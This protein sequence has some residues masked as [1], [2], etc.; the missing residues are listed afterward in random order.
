VISGFLF[1][2]SFLV[3]LAPVAALADVI[4][5][6]RGGLII[7]R[8]THEDSKQVTYEVPGGEVS[9][10]MSEVD[11]VVKSA[12]QAV[13]QAPEEN[14]TSPVNARQVPLPSAPS[15]EPSP[16]TDSP[17][18]KDGAIDEAYLVHLGN[19]LA[20]NPSAEN[21]HLLKQ[22]YQQAALF[23]ARQGDPDG[24]IQKY[25]EALKLLPGDLALTLA[26]GYLQVTQNHY[27]EAIDLLLPAADLHPKSA[28]IPMLLGSAY[29]GMENLDEA[30][31]QWN[32]ALDISDNPRI[33]AAIAKTEREREISGSYSELRSEHFL[34]RYEGRQGEKLS[35]EVLN[36]LEKS[37][38]DLVFDLDYNP[39]ETIVVLLYPD[40]AFRDI[41]RSPS[42]V[43]A[44]ND[45]KI[46]VPVS[47]LSQLNADL[48]RVL[49]HEL[50]HS[51]VRQITGGR[52]PTWFNE[53]L[54]QIEEGATTASM[55]SRLARAVA[56]G[57]L[58][59]LAS[60][61]GPAASAGAGQSTSSS[62]LQGP[63]LT[64]PKDQAV[65]AYAKS[66][67][68]VEYL[69]SNFDMSEIRRLLKA[70]PSQPDFGALLQDELHYNYSGF[71]QEVA[72]YI[73]RK[74][75]T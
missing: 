26:L 12:S 31:A 66:L 16:K 1:F 24:A 54:A 2:L 27:L 32:K 38:Q 34:L 13:E 28:D 39:R 73:V 67:A 5:L 69:R 64:L 47:G 70:I 42:W 40:Q 36:S 22:G 72:Y 10:P 74:Y 18:F 56:A 4:Y 59:S 30:I 49:K 65:L 52:C 14:Q 7:A 17:V 15:V 61:E 23:L 11:H 53:G 43:G 51:F 55:G 21:S 33:H 41:T 19:E 46:R 68:A 60:L 37:F 75:G 62:S 8:V 3:T 6:K 57:T 35:D 58:P 48:V 20:H 44:I 9:L 29:Y 71:D 25:Q 63:F 50:T 45:G